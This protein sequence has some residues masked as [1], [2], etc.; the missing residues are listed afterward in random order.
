M[1]TVRRGRGGA[2]RAA[3]RRSA[4]RRLR[5]KKRTLARF[6]LHFMRRRTRTQRADARAR[7]CRARQVSLPQRGAAAA[8]SA[9][10]AH[11]LRRAQRRRFYPPR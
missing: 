10:C 4:A 7:A 8:R 1:N 6:L 5:L 2:A 3:Q 11:A 9:R